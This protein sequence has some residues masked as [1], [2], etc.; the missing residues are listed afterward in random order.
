MADPSSTPDLPERDGDE[1]RLREN[2]TLF[3]RT[4]R[5]AG[6][7]VGPERVLEALR[8][9]QAVGLE[10][11][12]DLYWALHAVFVHRKDQ[13]PLFDQAFHLFWRNPRILDRVMQML[14]PEFQTQ[15]DDRQNR[16]R[17]QRRLAEAMQQQQDQ[18]Q[19][20]EREEH[21]VDATLTWS[22]QDVEQTKDFEQMSTEEVARAKKAIQALSLPIDLVRTRRYRA[23][24]HPG[25][26]DLRRT[27]RAALRGGSGHIPIKWRQQK[28]RPPPLVLVCDISGS[29]A[30]YSRMVLQFMHSVTNDRDRVYSFVFGTRLTN[31]THYLRTS[32]VDQAL[33]KVGNT[34]TDWEGGTRIGACLHD[35][36]KRWAR[37]VLG[38]G[39]VVLLITDG[40]DRDNADG[41]A[42]EMERLHKSCRRLVWLNPLLR[43]QGY[44]PKSQGARAILPH[45]DEFRPVHNLD[46]LSELADALSRPIARRGEGVGSWLE[47]IE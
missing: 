4:L 33:A 36:N 16:E 22:Q 2:L 18:G 31:I 12:D 15:G 10:R 5:A 7:P 1:G 39:A 23:A 47:M 28:K 45:V 25:R 44:A 14:L 6:L 32:D 9:V 11:R 41:L 37:R 20:P 29:M 3:A 40:L 27:M 34:V 42:D 38:Q 19:E 8:V 26:A 21:E 30:R 43:Y 24:G 13:Q 17:L 35:F 46:S